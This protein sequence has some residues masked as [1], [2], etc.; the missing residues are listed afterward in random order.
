[1]NK[2]DKYLRKFMDWANEQ[3]DLSPEFLQDKWL[4]GLNDLHEAGEIT[5][6]EMEKAAYALRI[7]FSYSFHGRV[8]Y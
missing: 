2:M 1:M 4:D 8:R 6:E 7:G 3:T 5:E